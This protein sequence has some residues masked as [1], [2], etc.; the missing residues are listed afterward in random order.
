MSASEKVRAPAQDDTLEK[1]V[2]LAAIG[3]QRAKRDLPHLLGRRRDVYDAARLVTAEKARLKR[4]QEQAATAAQAEDRREHVAALHEE[5]RSRCHQAE[6]RWI[7]ESVIDVAACARVVAVFRELYSYNHTTSH[8]R[9]PQKIAVWTMIR[10]ALK[11]GDL[12]TPLLV[13]RYERG[14]SLAQLCGCDPA[15]TKITPPEED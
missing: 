15:P 12:G 4:E 2:K 8:L 7:A 5:A 1:T 11:V 3:N 14:L 10:L 13:E 6:Q 9:V